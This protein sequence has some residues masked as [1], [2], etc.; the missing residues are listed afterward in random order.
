[1]KRINI[2]EYKEYLDKEDYEFIY[3]DLVDKSIKLSK[4]IAKMKK[5]KLLK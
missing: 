1:M 4:D 5:I 3:N 2:E